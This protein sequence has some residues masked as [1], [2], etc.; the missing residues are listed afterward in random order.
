MD[1][2]DLLVDKLS[3]LIDISV[4]PP[5]SK[6]TGN[7]KSTS[8]QAPRPG[9]QTRHLVAVPVAGNTGFFDVQVEDN[10]FDHVSDPSVLFATIEQGAPEA[11]HT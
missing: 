7:S 10:L 3:K 9:D 1:K 2:R 6:G 4:N 11:I 8:A 5:A